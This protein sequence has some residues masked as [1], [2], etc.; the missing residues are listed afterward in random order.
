MKNVLKT[1]MFV[2]TL[3]LTSNVL[4]AEIIGNDKEYKITQRD[5]HSSIVSEKEYSNLSDFEK[6]FVDQVDASLSAIEI[7]TSKQ[8]NEFIAS[9]NYDS[10]KRTFS[11]IITEYSS[12]DMQAFESNLLEEDGGGLQTYTCTACGT[13]SAASCANQ[14]QNTTQ[15]INNFNVNVQKLSN[16]CVKMTWQ[17]NKKST[18][19]N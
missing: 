4:K 6:R 18:S 11:S 16:G 12:I 2:C 3:L 7:L 8:K 13:V 19:I 1:I 15:G 14:I 5:G 9:I 10:S 17:G